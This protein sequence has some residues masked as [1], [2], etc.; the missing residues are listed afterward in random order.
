MPKKNRNSIDNIWPFE[1]RLSDINGFDGNLIH[2]AKSFHEKTRRSGE[3]RPSSGGLTPEHEKV[4]IDTG[5]DRY[6]R[7]ENVWEEVSN[8]SVC[9]SIIAEPFLSRFG[10]DIYRCVTCSHRYLNPRLKFPVAEELYANDKTASD[11]YT[12]QSQIEIDRKKYSYGIDLIEM[13][14]PPSTE[15][16]M[17]VGCGAGVFLE[18]A[19]ERG[20]KQC[21][22]IDINH[23]YKSRYEDVDGVQ[24]ILSSL[25]DLQLELVGGDYDCI[26]MWSVLEHIYDTQLCVERI[27]SLLKPNGLLFIL[28]PNIDSLATRV[29]RE[30]SPTFSWKHVSYFSPSSL[31]VLF[32]RHGLV[33]E[34][35]ETVISEIDNVKSYLSGEFPYEGYG[36]PHNYFDWIT[37][38][39]IH[40]NLL[41]SRLIGVFRNP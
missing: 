32:E 13:L 38:A 16:I 1:D 40:D 4:V 7:K 37:P 28:V 15:R 22:G 14:L 21:V 29:I 8:C 23:R 17:D 10:L 26:T 20:W 31:R 3:R 35:V 19:R 27:K 6:I 12:S 41:G 36:D 5:Q 33:C 30:K 2:G 9:G 18:V 24:Y 11:I 39:Y 34:H 25:E